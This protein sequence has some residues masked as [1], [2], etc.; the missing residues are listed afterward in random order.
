M[1][2]DITYF[3]DLGGM[4]EPNNFLSDQAIFKEAYIFIP[5]G[6]IRDIVVSFFSNWINT[7]SWVLAKPLTGFTETFSYYIMEMSEDGGSTKPDPDD[8]VESILFVVE[9]EPFLEIEKQ[10]EHL[11]PGCYAYIPPG[12]K[13]S[14]K[15]QKNTPAKFHWIRKVYEKEPDLVVPD[16]FVVHEQSL[17]PQEMPND[18]RWKTTRFVEPSDLRHDMHVNIVS[19]EPG[20]SIPFAETHV[21]EHAIYILQGKGTYYLNGDWVNVEAGDFMALRAFCPQ[22]CKALGNEPFRYL[23]YKNVNR[24][25][26]LRA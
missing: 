15:N 17:T 20:S 6:C 3:S 2:T 26:S 21:M 14:I 5:R 9:G 12:K 7:R 11:K 4:P 25:M 13:W 18:P 24:H 19:F 1:K 8:S 16:F 23:L 10:K 22:A